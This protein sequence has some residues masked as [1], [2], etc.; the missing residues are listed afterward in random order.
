MDRHTGFGR[1]TLGAAVLVFALTAASCDEKLSDLTGP[2]PSLEPTFSS[3][4]HEIFNATDSSGRLACTNCHSN[5]G[6]NPSGGMNLLEGLSYTQLVGVAST[7]KPGAVRVI[8]GDPENS[9][10]IHKLE[11]RSDITGVRMPRGN[12]P[13]LTEGQMLVIKRW[14]ANGAPN[15]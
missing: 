3:I 13:Y 14:I 4:Q 8:P 2:T 9:Y 10:I 15:N 11:G 6:R 7:G 5:Q 12:G 1:T